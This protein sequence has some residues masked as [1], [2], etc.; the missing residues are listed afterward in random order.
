MRV[1]IP[2][3]WLILTRKPIHLVNMGVSMLRVKKSGKLP[4]RDG[5]GS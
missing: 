1:R 5:T 2:M 3:K 4:R